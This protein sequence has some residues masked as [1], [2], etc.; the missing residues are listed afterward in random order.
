MGETPKTLLRARRPRTRDAR[1]PF[2]LR[3]NRPTSRLIREEAA[4]LVPEAI[5][6]PVELVESW[7]GFVGVQAWNSPSETVPLLSAS[8]E[9]SLRHFFELTSVSVNCPSASAS[10]ALK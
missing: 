7:L 6:E 5:V 8:A 10:V 9:L 3:I 4:G 2:Y 1:A